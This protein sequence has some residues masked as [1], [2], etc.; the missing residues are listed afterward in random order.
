A[1]KFIEILLGDKG[2]DDQEL[3][4]L[5]HELNVRPMIKHREFTPLHRAWNARLD[6]DLYGQRNQNETVNSTIGRKYDSSVF[7]RKWYKQ[8]REII[9]KCIV[10]NLDRAM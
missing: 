2:Y 5:C 3:R 9:A 7:S 4:K 10:R 8:F 1:S 6:E